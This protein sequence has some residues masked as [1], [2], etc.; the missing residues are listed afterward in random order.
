MD[1]PDL[2]HRP[3]G[4]E[5]NAMPLARYEGR[6]E[7]IRDP[8]ELEA[9]L[10]LLRAEKILGFDTE[11]RPSFRK[12]AQNSPSLIQLATAD[13]VFLIQLTWLPFNGEMASILADPGIVKAG[14]AIGDDMRELEKLHPFTPAGLADLGRLA[15]TA[16]IPSQGLRTLAANLFGIRISKGPQCSNWS[17]RELSHRQV[18]YAATDAWISRSIYLKMRE[19]GVLP[20]GA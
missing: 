4:E 20:E 15:K 19:L 18:A 1:L 16:G 7:L 14:A 2:R 9:A 13:A 17:N 8:R 10:P 3:S 12:G 6:V 5:I 11:T